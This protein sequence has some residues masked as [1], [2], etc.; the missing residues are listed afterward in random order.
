MSDHRI[1]N[2]RYERIHRSIEI[3]HEQGPYG[4]GSTDLIETEAGG[5]IIGSGLTSCARV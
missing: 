3:A 2:E 5:P 1:P 4:A